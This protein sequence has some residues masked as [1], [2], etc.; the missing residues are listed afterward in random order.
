MC[1]FSPLVSV[2]CLSHN[3]WLSNQFKSRM[4][5][6]TH[7]K[8]THTAPHPLPTFTCFLI[9]F[10]VWPLEGTVDTQV[11][12]VSHWVSPFAFSHRPPPWMWRTRGCP[13]S[14]KYLRANWRRAKVCF[15]HQGSGGHSPSHCITT[16]SQH[17]KSLYWSHSTHPGGDDYRGGCCRIFDHFCTVQIC[18][19]E[20]IL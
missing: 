17:R 4:R 2:L 10:S 7:Q 11:A 1:F 20:F 8:H 12:A 19:F 3:I 15:S 9:S 16:Q 14:G 18:L 5:P 6:G 13:R